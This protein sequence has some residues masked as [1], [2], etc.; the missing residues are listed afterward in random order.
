PPAG[1]ERGRR[2]LR[3]APHGGDLLLQ[4]AER[5]QRRHADAARPRV[6]PLARLL[7]HRRL[8]LSRRP[9][10]PARRALLLR[11]LLLR[12]DLERAAAAAAAPAPALAP[13]PWPAPPP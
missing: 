2:E 4:P 8:P 10:P 3:M 1:R 6:R 5:L 13:S 9:L 11:R 7:D 12:P